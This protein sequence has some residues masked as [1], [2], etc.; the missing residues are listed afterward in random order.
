MV[1]AGGARHLNPEVLKPR[2]DLANKQGAGKG[3]AGGEAGGWA[4]SWEDR[5]EA[6]GMQVVREPQ[7]KLVS[8]HQ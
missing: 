4:C 2:S 1:T 3:M 5:E 7:G 8:C 6:G